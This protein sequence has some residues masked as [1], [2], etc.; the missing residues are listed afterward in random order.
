MIRISVGLE[1][2]DDII[3]DMEQAFNAVEMQ[4]RG[5]EKARL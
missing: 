4:E 1:H 5:C 3:G 2:I